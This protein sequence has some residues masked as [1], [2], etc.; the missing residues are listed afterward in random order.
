MD[1]P[2]IYTRIFWNKDDLYHFF[3]CNYQILC[4]KISE[5]LHIRVKHCKKYWDS[6]WSCV[7]FSEY[8]PRYLKFLSCSNFL[9][10]VLLSSLNFYRIRW[11]SMKF[12]PRLQN[13]LTFYKVCWTSTNFA[14]L[15]QIWL[16]FNT[17][18][19]TS[20][21]FVDLLQTLLNFV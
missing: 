18:C 14:E 13:Q 16:S 2:L 11:I 4:K 12:L 10:K 7:M 20:M 19:W 21:K 9:E 6:L 17:V 5:T 8:L 15:L 3:S 1:N